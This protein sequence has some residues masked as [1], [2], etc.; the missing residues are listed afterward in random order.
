MPR[1]PRRLAQRRLRA[2][3]LEGELG[4]YM[5]PRAKTENDRLNLLTAAVNAMNGGGWLAPLIDPR[6][7]LDVGCGTGQ[8]AYSIAKRYRD[9]Q[10][11]GVDIENF[12]DTG[13]PANFKFQTVNVLNLRLPF[14]NHSFDY[15]HQRLMVAAYTMAKFPP[16]VAELVRV[17][18]PGGWV[19]LLE[20]MYPME[21]PGPVTKELWSYF[22]VLGRMGDHDTDGTIPEGLERYLTDAGL[23]NVVARTVEVPMGTWAVELGQTEGLVG[24]W[25]TSSMRSVLSALNSPARPGERSAFHMAG[26]EPERGREMIATMMTEIDEYR[27]AFTFKT[28]YGQVPT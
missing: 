9:S 15:V 28:A 19:E 12:L 21:R 3:E 11:V 20:T 7:V 25:M 5:L 10:V 13:A 14:E 2:M 16:G 26:L 8:W 27:S 22:E 1:R 6:D 24:Q 4:R 18:R 17:A 23:S